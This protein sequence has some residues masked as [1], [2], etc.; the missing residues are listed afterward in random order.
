MGNVLTAAR[1]ELHLLGGQ[2][3]YNTQIG[4]AQRADIDDNFNMVP[5]K[6]IGKHY[7]IGHEP[8]IYDGRGNLSV[9]RLSTQSLQQIGL[10][11]HK[12]L[13]ATLN[14]TGMELIIRDKRGTVV[15]QLTEVKFDTVRTSVDVGTQLVMEDVGFVFVRVIEEL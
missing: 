5:L 8:G 14:A 2:G 11:E 7:T 12:Y 15:D 10:R 4:L 1:L 6:G 13:V 3:G 9:V